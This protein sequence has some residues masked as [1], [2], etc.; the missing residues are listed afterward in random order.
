MPRISES[1]V[2]RFSTYLRSLDE[3][4]LEGK[5]LISS[6]ELALLSGVNSAQVRKDLS[7]IGSLGRR[8]LGYQVEPLRKE[9]RTILGLSREWL[10]ALV[11]AG[12]IGSALVSYTDFDR[13]GFKIVAVF[14]NANDRIGQRL[15]SHTIEPITHFP[16]VVSRHS[17]EI[18][19]IATP[20][21]DAQEVADMMVT[22]GV[23]A[24]LNFAPRK[25]RL[26]ED[27]I[28]RAVNMTH[29]LESL[30]F[31]LSQDTLR[32]SRRSLFSD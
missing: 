26:P 13:Q 17:V 12:N 32:S 20:A 19:V 21:H 4:S 9:I 2:R 6:R 30:S 11:G 5:P 27:V 22:S 28:H 7:C 23:R 29:E 18:G 8:G 24:V 31:M 3:F 15:G 1:T 10:L 25:L 14:D 16:D